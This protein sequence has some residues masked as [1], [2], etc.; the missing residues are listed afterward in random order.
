MLPASLRVI[1]QGALSECKNLKSVKFGEGLE[2]LGTDEHMDDGQTWSGVFEE[3]AVESVELPSTLK[4]IEYNAF[5]KCENLKSIRVPEKLECV[6]KGC[7]FESA[8]ESIRIPSAVQTIEEAAFSRCKNLTEVVFEE[9]SSLKTIE[10]ETFRLC[11][12]LAKINFPE[13]LER[14]GASAFMATGLD[15]VVLPTSLRTVAQEAFAD[16]AHLRSVKFGEGLE[17]LGADQQR[18]DDES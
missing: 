8:L 14:I 11:N 2:V 10:R 17:V 15:N 13:G 12:N 9:G 18:G 3:S 5:M 6:C 1:A 7:F 16:C 4:R